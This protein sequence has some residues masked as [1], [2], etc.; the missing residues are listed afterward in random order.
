MK[1]LPLPVRV[2]AGL[3]VTAV[4]RARHLP[5]KLAGLPVTMVSQAL[6][7]SMRV[8]QQVTELAIKGDDALSTLRSAEES[9]EWATF[10]E[11][12]TNGDATHVARSPFDAAEADNDGEAV[13]GDPWAAEE[14]AMLHELDTTS[15]D[16]ADPESDTVETVDA[17]TLDAEDTDQDDEIEDD[18][19]QPAALPHYTHLTLP[20]VR[21]R[22]RR[23]N[24][25]Q[26]TEVVKFERAHENRPSFVG[27]LNRR[28]ATL[29]DQ[30]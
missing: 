6:Q 3:A 20:Q 7:L 25:K 19:D 21:A 24:I 23:L 12:T 1:P 27:M 30:R 4:D 17:A 2:A 18:E 9:P 28:I 22:M 26:L 13:A 15:T 14:R 8:Q 10:D 16:G 11:D 29:R 5:E